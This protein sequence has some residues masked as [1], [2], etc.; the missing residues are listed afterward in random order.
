MS[1]L[2]EARVRNPLII[3]DE[4]DKVGGRTHNHGDPSA[5]LLE[6]LDPEQNTHFRDVYLD[7]PVDLSEVLFIATANDLAGI[8]APW[9]RLELIE[10]LGYADEEKVDMVR[11]KPVERATRGQRAERRRLL[12]PRSRQG[13]IGR[14]RRRR[15]A[16]CW[17]SGG[18]RWRCSMARRRRGR[19]PLRRWTHPRRRCRD[20]SR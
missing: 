15:P 18:W 16:P 10:A 13:G 3:L 1:A 2:R 9:D 20:R 17:S 12:G 8:P 4:I 6:V 19:R 14:N 11:P 5:A 7:V